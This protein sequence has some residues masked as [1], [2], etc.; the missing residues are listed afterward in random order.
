[1]PLGLIY[2]E[3]L[4]NAFKLSGK[5]NGEIKVSLKKENGKATLTVSDNGEPLPDDFEIENTHT[6]GMTLAKTLTTQ[7]EGEFVVSQ[8]AWTRFEFSFSL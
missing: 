8:N 6:L 4:N 2:N 1:M 7:L 5:D 3:L